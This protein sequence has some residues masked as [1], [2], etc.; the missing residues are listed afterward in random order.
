MTG[1]EVL[2]A[3]RGTLGRHHRLPAALFACMLALSAC[4]RQQPSPDASAVQVLAPGRLGSGFV[5]N[6]NGDVVTAFHLIEDFAAHPDEI[7]VLET[8]GKAGTRHHATQIPWVSRRLDLAVIHVDGLTQPPAPLQAGEPRK[9]E[10]VHA[11]GFPRLLSDPGAAPFAPA[12]LD[13]AIT[14]VRTEAGDRLR[15]HDPAGAAAIR[16]IEHS[17]TLGPGSSGGPLFNACG[18]VVGINTAGAVPNGDSGTG[19]EDAA[20]A[21]RSASYAIPVSAL[22]AELDQRGFTYQVAGTS[23]GGSPGQPWFYLAAGAAFA[24][25]AMVLLARLR[26]R[27]TPRSASGQGWMLSGVGR[28]GR[29]IRVFGRKADLAS[30]KGSLTIGRDR[31]RCEIVID[32]PTVSGHHARLRMN[33]QAGPNPGSFLVEDLRSTNGTFVDAK[34]VAPGPDKAVPLPVGATLV[35]G[36]CR[37]RLTRG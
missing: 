27:K 37:V 7:T 21:P 6:R 11:V 32:D 23:C 24:A 17:A 29:A 1:P 15:S 36:G 8:R 5:L 22:T 12:V 30:A 16:V 25:G 28:V 3:A 34:R 18:A 9:A 35:I 33:P 4:A 14:R 2:G 20:A 10:V 19:A 26:H 31:R 13:G